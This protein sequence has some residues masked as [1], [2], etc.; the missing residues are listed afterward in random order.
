[1]ALHHATSGEVVDLNAVAAD[2]A[3]TKTRALVKSD[4][5]EAIHLMVRA[6]NQIPPHQVAGQFTLL[7]L[8]GRVKLG[9]ADNE[10][11]LS[12]GQWV[13]FDGGVRHT[14][15]A[16]EDSSLLLTIIFGGPDE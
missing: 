13:F 2:L 15:D 9:L 16:L 4:S 12:A 14:V 1:V 10:V 3:G 8:E 7:C 11:E 5:F 6:G